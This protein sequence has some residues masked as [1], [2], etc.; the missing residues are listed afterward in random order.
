[1]PG[2]F[3]L[4]VVDVEVEF[5]NEIDPVLLLHEEKVCE[6]VGD[7]EIAS[8]PAS[9]Q[10]VAE[11]VIVPSPE[12]LTAKA[13]WYCAIQFHVIDEGVLIVKLIVVVVPE[14]E[15]APVPFQPV[16][17]YLVWPDWFAGL[18][19]DAVTEEPESC[20]PLFGLGAPCAVVIFR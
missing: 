2:P 13:I 14:A 6:P 1:M 18:A 12:G 8:V 20:H 3:R 10:L 11:G 9:Y 4:A 7:A 16:H 17:L 5:V 15:T 19:I